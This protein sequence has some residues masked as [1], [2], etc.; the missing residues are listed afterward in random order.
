MEKV[1]I[2]PAR[3]HVVNGEKEGKN[4]LPLDDLL[5]GTREGGDLK[6]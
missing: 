5:G 3:T 6:I 1:I 4:S 2:K